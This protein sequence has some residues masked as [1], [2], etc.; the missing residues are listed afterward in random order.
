MA[1]PR[2]SVTLFIARVEGCA[3]KAGDLQVATPQDIEQAL[4]QRDI[5][6]L[7]GLMLEAPGNTPRVR[8][9]FKT[10]NDLWEFK[11]DCPHLGRDHENAW[12]HFA[13]DVLAF[14]NQKGGLIV[15]G[16]SDLSYK[17]CGTSARLDSKI[18]NDHLRRYIG[19][20][21]W[22]EYIRAFVQED[23]RYVG[24]AIVPP[25][26][27]TLGR[28]QADAPLV[29]GRRLFETEQSALREGDTSR[30]LSKDESDQ[31]SQRFFAPRIDQVLAV[32]E[33]LFRILAP[34][35]HHFTE[36]DE[37]CRLIESALVS[38]RA[39]VTSVIGIGGVGKTALATWA[40]LRS[41]YRRSFDFIVSVT[42]KDRELTSG[43]IKAIDQQLTSF[44]AL[45]DAILD[46]FA[47]GDY[48]TL[49]VDQREKR[50]RECLDAGKGLLYV[51]NLETV[52]D[53]RIIAFLD[54][55]PVGTRALV[56][57]RRSRVRV[58]VVP[59]DLGPL[60][61]S[62]SSAFIGSLATLPGLG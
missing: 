40:V 27:P 2:W 59:V 42:A 39:A 49:P 48:K 45:L 53:S 38:K 30:L 7:I 60:T 61:E 57:S 37:P 26:G 1:R 22:I 19:D 17:Y 14:H 58:S 54:D 10:E 8:D 24:I 23:Q 21:I 4:R 35:Y 3:R 25:R 5:D 47:L 43:G 15:F 62:E 56:T 31:V 29:N 13:K 46:T 34:E 20:R 6:T 18:V 44:E 16:F 52:D 50:V 12:A 36:R 9:G 33:P 28:F 51:D 55:L 11:S 41:Y 32:D